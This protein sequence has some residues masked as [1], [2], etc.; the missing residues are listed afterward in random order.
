MYAVLLLASAI[1]ILEF[2]ELMAED[3]PQAP[4]VSHSAQAQPGGTI[5]PEAKDGGV[6]S[7]QAVEDEC[8]EDADILEEELPLEEKEGEVLERRGE[9]KKVRQVESTEGI[10][11]EYYHGGGREGN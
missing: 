4:A 10:T 1:F 2:S 9:E 5:E 6:E 3:Q 11:G 8:C 7:T